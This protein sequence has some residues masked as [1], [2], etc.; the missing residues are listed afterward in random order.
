[1]TQKKA[2]DTVCPF[3]RLSRRAFETG[4]PKIATSNA[5]EIFGKRSR[6]H[7]GKQGAQP[8]LQNLPCGDEEA[9]GFV[10]SGAPP[11]TP[12]HCAATEQRS[13]DGALRRRDRVTLFRRPTP[14]AIRQNEAIMTQKKA[15]DTVCPF[16]RLPPSLCVGGGGGIRTPVTFPSNGFQDRLVVTASIRLRTALYCNRARRVC[17]LF[18]PIP[19]ANG[20]PQ[21]VSLA[22]Y[23]A[24]NAPQRKRSPSL[25]EVRPAAFAA[26][27]K[28]DHSNCA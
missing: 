11:A 4:F 15:D 2:D 3:L 27:R 19:P 8:C 16:L 14:R 23:A 9:E 24:K 20:T 22:H 28:T 10:R 17:Q 18:R 1:M 6:R 21:T 25:G 13:F 12:S 26:G 5:R 7:F